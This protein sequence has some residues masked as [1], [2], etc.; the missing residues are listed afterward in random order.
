MRMRTIMEARQLQ[1]TFLGLC[2]GTLES[3]E[4]HRNRI[5]G[6]AFGKLPGLREFSKFRSV[7]L[8]LASDCGKRVGRRIL[9]IRIYARI[10]LHVT[11]VHAH[12]HALVVGGQAIDLFAQL[13]V[14]LAAPILAR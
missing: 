1:R 5:N 3:R 4:V 14:K 12:L 9:D 7:N 6:F 13:V 2:A 10:D 11:L 8:N